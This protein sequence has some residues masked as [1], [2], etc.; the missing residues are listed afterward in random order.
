ME[1]RR[2][3]PATNKT[4]D[5][6][7]AATVVICKI[8]IVSHHRHFGFGFMMQPKQIVEMRP[9]IFSMYSIIVTLFRKNW[10]SGFH[11]YFTSSICV[12]MSVMVLCDCLGEK[13]IASEDFLEDVEHGM[14]L[15]QFQVVMVV[16]IA[17]ASHEAFGLILTSIQNM[18]VIPKSPC[19][20][21]RFSK[22]FMTL[23]LIVPTLLILF[24]AI[25]SASVELFALFTMIC[26][27]FF[28]TGIMGH[29]W[30]QGG[31][32]LRTTAFIL[33][34]ASFSI[35][36][37]LTIYEQ[38]ISVASQYLFWISVYMLVAGVALIFFCSMKYIGSLRARES[39]GMCVKE[40]NC[41]FQIV[42]IGILAVAFIVVKLSVHEKF[43]I[44]SLVY[45]CS[46]ASVFRIIFSG[47]QTLLLRIEIDD[48]TVRT[49]TQ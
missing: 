13:A 1:S 21:E 39:R 29:L 26:V 28:V 35:A 32:A 33:A 23:S 9:T 43:G 22:F 31:E 38:I 4:V 27:L 18:M 37:V 25:P 40:I 15:Q 19:Q 36:F 45:M 12:F 41:A 30:S 24:V 46:I 34:H 11:L 10:S 6:V 14:N 3:S 2:K 49:T 16:N 42:L 47:V 20:A 5:A 17:I 48:K 44:N 8:D 7:T